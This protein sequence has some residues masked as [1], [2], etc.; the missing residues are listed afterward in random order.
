VIRAVGDPVL[1]FKEDALRLLRAVRFAGR[2]GFTIEEGTRLA[3]SAEAGLVKKVSVERIREE[4]EKM[5]LD[6][7]PRQAFLDLETLGLLEYVLPEIST[8]KIEQRKV[9]EQTLRVLQVLSRTPRQER[10]VF[11]W[12]LL[13]LPSFRLQ[14]IEKRD[15][16]SRKFSK[17]M[18]FSVEDAELMA[19][20]V[21]ETPKFR[22]A[23]SMRE[24][25]LLRW[26][27]HPEFEML[28]RFHELDAT[29]YDGN[30]AGL[31]FVRSAYPEARRRFERKPL[32]TGEDLV[33]LGLEPGPR[34]SEILRTIEDLALEGTLQT[35]EEALNHVLNHF[36][37]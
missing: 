18:K 2:F 33:K 34:F 9:R 10:P 5:L 13:L 6:P 15:A 3:I 30:L 14:P 32:L 24:A 7:T 12:T 37:R 25:T 35:E 17:R 21:R 4:L 23:F 22:E 11:Y 28:M 19:Y 29:S 16:E 36:V 20:L 8:A 1:R 31:E 26:M 27:R